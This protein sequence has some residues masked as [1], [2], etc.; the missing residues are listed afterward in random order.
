MCHEN[1]TSTLWLMTLLSLV[2]SEASFTH[3]FKNRFDGNKRLCSHSKFEFSRLKKNTNASLMYKW[4]LTYEILLDS[5]SCT[6]PLF[7]RQGHVNDTGHSPLLGLWVN[8]CQSWVIGVLILQ[9]R[10]FSTSYEP[11]FF[12]WSKDFTI[13][14]RTG[15]LHVNEYFVVLAIVTDD[16]ARYLSAVVGQV[17]LLPWLEIPNRA[18]YFEDKEDDDI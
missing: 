5:L 17:N 18:W 15:W 2:W 11:Q 14:I 12:Q 3:N 10:R 16:S 6:V 9:P 8:I 7:C 4:T 13:F 1:A